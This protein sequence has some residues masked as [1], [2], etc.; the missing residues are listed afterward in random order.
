MDVAEAFAA[1]VKL[2]LQQYIA[3][4]E[5]AVQASLATSARECLARGGT[6]TLSIDPLT[7][8]VSGVCSVP[9]LGGVP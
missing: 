4:A 2:G 8:V 7:Q 6:F 9:L 3:A 1:M 5:A